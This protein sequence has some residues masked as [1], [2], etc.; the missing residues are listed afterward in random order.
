MDVGCNNTL[1]TQRYR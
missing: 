1:A